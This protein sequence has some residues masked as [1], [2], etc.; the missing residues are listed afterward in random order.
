MHGGCG[1][2]FQDSNSP[3]TTRDRALFAGTIFRTNGNR[4]VRKIWVAIER[5][6]CRKSAA[7]LAAERAVSVNLK[8]QGQPWRERPLRTGAGPRRARAA[9]SLTPWFPIPTA[10]A[11]PAVGGKERRPTTEV[12]VRFR[13][14]LP[15]LE[16]VT[17]F[18][19]STGAHV[20]YGR[21]GGHA[22]RPGT[23]SIFEVGPEV[24]L[25]RTPS[26]DVNQ[27]REMEVLA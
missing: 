18:R 13:H 23:T 21:A 17:T 2:Y 20:G 15:A 5:V 26:G 10:T 4:I 27:V 7:L 16:M 3:A 6:R 22:C 25:S 14:E 9:G 19:G 24:V 8:R 12:C 11:T 1:L